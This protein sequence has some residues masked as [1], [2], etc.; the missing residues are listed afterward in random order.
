MKKCSKCG[1]LKPL[2]MFSKNSQSKDG[3]RSECKECNKKYNAEQKEKRKEWWQKYKET[4]K[5]DIEKYR[6][7]HAEEH[8]VKSREYYYGHKEECNERSRKYHSAHKEEAKE[9]MSKYRAEHKDELKNKKAEYYKTERGKAT[10]KAST[11]KRRAAK[12]QNGGSFSADEWEALCGLFDNKCAYCG[13]SNELTADHI[14]PLSKGGTNNI[15]NILPACKK[16]NS[17]KHAKGLTEWFM[18][19]T[20]F[21]HER[22]NKILSYMGE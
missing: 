13:D 8:K 5:E 11:Q 17:S 22:Y 9:K 6:A 18:S 16:C 10:H 2:E 21:T 14:V 15:A 7:E 1:E 19:K 20:F 12:A 3:L 4:H